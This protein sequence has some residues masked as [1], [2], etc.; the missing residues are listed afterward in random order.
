M[1][2]WATGHQRASNPCE[3]WGSR[4]TSAVAPDKIDMVHETGRLRL[5]HDQR[6]AS[7]SSRCSL[8][9]R[10]TVFP[11]VARFAALALCTSQHRG[12]T[13]LLSH[14]GARFPFRQTLSFCFFFSSFRAYLGS[15]PLLLSTE[16][17]D[18]GS[19]S[20]VRP[21]AFRVFRT[22][23]CGERKR[24]LWLCGRPVGG[25]KL[26]LDLRNATT[27]HTTRFSTV[28]R[29]ASLRGDLVYSLLLAGRRR[30]PGR[31]FTASFRGCSMYGRK[32]KVYSFK[33]C[34]PWIQD[35][36][37]FRAYSSNSTTR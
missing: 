4:N 2:N 11:H 31:P 1:Q 25:L 3:G 32:K 33:D 28:P 29:R 12:V 36:S 30:H 13:F 17:S 18:D 35:L 7:L 27:S 8:S 9:N 22:T 19:V 6:L 23:A 10:L 24:C 34:E 21:G 16:T 37:C 26:N 5:R 15:R 14:G 20:S